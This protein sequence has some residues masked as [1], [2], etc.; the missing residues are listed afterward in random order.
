M[1]KGFTLIELLVVIAIIAILAAILFPVF[2][3]ARE[4]ARQTSCLSNEKQL[5]LGCKMY[6][7]DN[8]G[9][10]PAVTYTPN[11]G[12]DWWFN[13]ISPYVNNNQLF[14]CPATLS[15]ASWLHTTYAP[16]WAMFCWD[17]FLPEDDCTSPAKTVYLWESPCREYTRPIAMGNPRISPCQ[18]GNPNEDPVPWVAP[19]TATH[20]EGE[21]LGYVDGHVKWHRCIAVAQNYTTWRNWY[22]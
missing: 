8:E 16:D 21:N 20:S 10:F 3:K 1:K 4:K 17:N 6:A 12:F 9:K 22:Q 13:Q 11:H 15:Y 19:W 2:A 18:T 14:L 5:I 7:T